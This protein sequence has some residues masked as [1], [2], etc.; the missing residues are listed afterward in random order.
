MPGKIS[1]S[2]M[3]ANFMELRNDLKALEKAHIDYLH[4]D[5]MDG[6]FVPNYTF[7]PNFLDQIRKNTDIPFDIHLMVEKPEQKIAYFNFK[8]SDLVSVHFEAANHLQRLL[9][10][11]KETGATPGVALNPSTPV[12]MVEEVLDDIGF[13]L[14]MCVNLGF[15]GQTLIPQCVNKIRRLREFLDA[16][17]Y[18]QI[19]IEVDGNVSF[20]NAKI[21]REAGADI[22]VAGTSG[23]FMNGLGVNKAET[24]LRTAI[25]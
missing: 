24:R 16:S 2:M 25:E 8:K 1:A 23:L 14:I 13:V 20:E 4:F 7:G 18:S 9:S 17:G 5:I 15:A 11:I 19:Q 21:M 3:C 12:S 22:F 10:A 6:I